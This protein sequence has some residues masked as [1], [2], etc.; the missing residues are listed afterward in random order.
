MPFF[1]GFVF[2]QLLLDNDY[3]CNCVTVNATTAVCTHSVT[4]GTYITQT[5]LTGSIVVQW[6][7]AVDWAVCDRRLSDLFDSVWQVEGG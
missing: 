7:T 1:A 4:T 6:L 2:C 3:C 5:I